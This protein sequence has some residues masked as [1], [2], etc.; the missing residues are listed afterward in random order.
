MKKL[1]HLSL[2]F[3][4]T[5]VFSQ[6]GVGTTTP[7]ADLDVNG[8]LRV[9][10]SNTTTNNTAAKDSILVTDN[11]GNVKRISSKTVIE[12]HLK[13][14]V[15]GAFVSSSDVSLTLLAGT[16]II[17]FDFEEFDLNNEFNTSTSVFTVKQDGIYEINIQIKATSAISVATDF[18]VVILKNGTIVNRNS[19]AN[20]GILGINA[21]PPS[22]SINTLVSL[23]I[24]D[25]ISFN[26]VASLLS[27]GLIGNREDCYFTIH[28]VR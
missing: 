20:I 16:K 10:T 21:T 23:T 1:L 3:F 25:T 24:G 26:V 15:K 28:Q 7:T 17:P 14:F 22:R 2:V 11:L 13:T 19:F 18:G 27:L 4:V 8:T 12:S 6:V 9:R 5:N